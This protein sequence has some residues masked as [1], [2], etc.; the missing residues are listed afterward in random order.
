MVNTSGS[1]FRDTEAI[2][3]RLWVFAVNKS[4]KIATIVKDEVE[5]LA[6]LECKKLLFQ[7]PVVF[8]LSLTL[9]CKPVFVSRRN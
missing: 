7:A 5:L 8:F 9:P 4:S 2:L 1:L 3:Q 6:T